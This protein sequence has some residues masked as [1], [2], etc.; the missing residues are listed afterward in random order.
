MYEQLKISSEFKLRTSASLNSATHELD[1]RNKKKGYTCHK[2]GQTKMLLVSIFLSPQVAFFR[3]TLRCDS[4]C[5]ESYVTTPLSAAR[6]TPTKDWSRVDR[7]RCPFEICA[8]LSFLK[9]DL[10]IEQI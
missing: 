10:I 9:E 8:D 2:E 4:R 5:P 7:D 3:P 1:F 6:S